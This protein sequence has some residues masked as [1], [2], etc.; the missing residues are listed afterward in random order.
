MNGVTFVFIPDGDSWLQS[1]VDC[2]DW[3]RKTWPDAIEGQDHTPGGDG[4]WGWMIQPAGCAWWFRDSA[5]AV[6]FKLRWGGNK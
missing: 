3:I 4:E 5:K 2:E 6:F 1:Q